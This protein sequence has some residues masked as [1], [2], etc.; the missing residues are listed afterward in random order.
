MRLLIDIDGVLAEFTTSFSKIAAELGLVEA[1]FGSSDVEQ[2]QWIPKESEGQVWDVVKSSYNWWMSLE[3]LIGPQEVT[4]L[5]DMID[6]HDV[7]FV[8]SRPRTKGLSAEKQSEYWLSGIGVNTDKAS[9]IATK[10]GTKGAL[11]SALNIDIGWDD[12]LQNLAD[13]HKHG[14]IAVAR[15]WKY[16]DSWVMPKCSNVYSFYAFVE[17]VKR[18]A[19]CNA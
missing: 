5:N 13:L 6:K 19:T 10:T 3:P 15:P 14:V 18:C 1:P 16:N 12:H 4:L 8:T 17:R 7:Y 11:A 2:W 9:V